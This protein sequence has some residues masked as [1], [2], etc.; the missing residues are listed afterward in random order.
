MRYLIGF[1]VVAVVAAAALRHFL[2]VH[3]GFTG[4]EIRKGVLTALGIGIFL[5]I[6]V[7]RW[8]RHL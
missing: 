2:H 6:A 4:E 3:V 7:V 1:F 5:A 8:R